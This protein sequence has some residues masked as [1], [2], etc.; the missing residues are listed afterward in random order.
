MVHPF[1]DFEN[2][3]DF[4]HNIQVYGPGPLVQKL[5]KRSSS[6]KFLHNIDFV[7]V[8]GESFEDN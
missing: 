5:K 6:A 8:I 1:R 7:L 2:N 4:F 3:L